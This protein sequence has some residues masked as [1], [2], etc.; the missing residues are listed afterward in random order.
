VSYGLYLYHP[1]VFIA[2]AM[3]ARRF[4]IDETWWLALIKLAACIAL[5]SLS[6]RYIE[7]PV[8]AWRSRFKYEANRMA[9]EGPV[10]RSL[11][12]GRQPA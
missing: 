3:S 2:I 4:G 5:A 7:L 1:L 6:W 11:G 10:T 8:L 9:S 12:A